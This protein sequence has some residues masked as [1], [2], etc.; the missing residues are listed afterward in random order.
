VSAQQSGPSMV[1]GVLKTIAPAE[2]YFARCP[3]P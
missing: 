2:I 3:H 1:N